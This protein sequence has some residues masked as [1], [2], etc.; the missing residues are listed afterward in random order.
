MGCFRVVGKVN[1]KKLF[2]QW[3][4]EVQP[5][6]SDPAESWLVKECK[7]FENGEAIVLFENKTGEKPPYYR[8]YHYHTDEGG[9]EFEKRV[10]SH[11]LNT[12]YVGFGYDGNVKF[13]VEVNLKT[14][15]PELWSLAGEDEEGPE[16]DSINDISF[17]D[18]SCDLFWVQ[19]GSELLM[20]KRDIDF[21]MCSPDGKNEIREIYSDFEFLA[22]DTEYVPSDGIYDAGAA[23]ED[24]N[25]GED[26]L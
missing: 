22:D 17:L 21:I 4:A 3:K 13:V 20:V 10:K 9:L 23:G 11:S 1:L 24:S 18:Q 2:R 26:G 6:D 19:N 14:G 15:R 7:V 25:D 8:W 16:G 12:E 5:D